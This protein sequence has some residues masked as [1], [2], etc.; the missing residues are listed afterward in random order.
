MTETLLLALVLLPGLVIA[1]VFHEVAHG[2]VAL[3][4]GDPTAKERRRLTLNPLRHVDPVGTVLLPG[5]LALAGLP[6]FGWAKPVPVN[7]ERL[8][9]PRFGMMAV[10]AAGPGTNLL[11]AA[12]AAI[13]LGL[14]AG[15]VTVEPDG[16]AL[17]AI[18]ALQYFLLINIFLA[19]FNLLPIPPF[20]GSHIVEGLLPARAARV[21]ERLR[22]FGIGLLFLLLLVIPWLFPG[23]GVVENLVLPPVEWLRQKY[24]GLAAFVA[25]V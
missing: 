6:V 14:I 5:G 3:M 8:D 7:K 21:Y 1:I 15:A 2:W 16:A 23:L 9:N 13:A 20:D 10:A 19:L 25:G 12:V 11:L 4:L 24:V 22:P 17:L 18:S